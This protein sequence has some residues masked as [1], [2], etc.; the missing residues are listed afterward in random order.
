MVSS[1]L[2]S[3]MRS[4]VRSSTRMT[5]NWFGPWWTTASTTSTPRATSAS[6]TRVPLSSEPITPANFERSPSVA[7]AAS[8]VAICP[9]HDT[10]WLEMR[11]FECGP[12]ASGRAGRR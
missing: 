1:R 7:H 12:S 4:P 11:I 5:A 8:A 2:Q 9:P 10:V 6:C 3:T